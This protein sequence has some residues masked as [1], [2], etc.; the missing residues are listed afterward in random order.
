MRFKDDIERDLARLADGT[1]TGERAR[2]VEARVA[3]SAELRAMLDEQRR[4]IGALRALDDR[5]PAVLRARIE[6]ARRGRGP[7]L[8]ARRL[9][10]VGALAAG[11]AVAAIA[12]VA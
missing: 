9:G 1:L 10:V 4:A 7:V 11:T 12:L 2:E 3:E 8:R 5:A 6:A